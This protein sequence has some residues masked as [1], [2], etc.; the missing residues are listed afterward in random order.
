MKDLKRLFRKAVLFG[1]VL[2]ALDLGL[3]EGLRA[4]YF[5]RPAVDANADLRDLFILF[6]KT[7]APILILGSSRAKNHYYPPLFKAAFGKDCFNAGAGGAFIE[8]HE[9]VLEAVLARYTPEIVVLDVGP[10]DFSKSKTRR[11]ALA[12][13]LPYYRR[14]PEIRP[15]IKRRSPFERIKLASRIY[16][17]NSWLFTLLNLNLRNP[18]PI[19]LESD[20]YTPMTKE[21]KAPQWELE[22]D[23]V[24]ALDPLALRSFKAIL[25]RSKEKGI[26]LFVFVSPYYSKTRKSYYALDAAASICKEA[27][28]PFFNMWDEGTIRAHP[29]YFSSVIH[30][31][32]SGAQAFSRLAIEEMRPFLGI[33]EDVRKSR[34][35]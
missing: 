13:L 1:L 20:G 24:I 8:Y 18:G 25:S 15:V 28:V 6:E 26:K 34:P 21:M 32:T 4:L 33:R 31:N 11:L 5:R 14:H 17:F 12:S 9:A 23:R 3:G 35:R 7:T 29:E 16:P 10:Y 2:W 30:L 22:S 19:S 27:G